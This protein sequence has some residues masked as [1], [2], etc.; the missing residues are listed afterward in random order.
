[1]HKIL[2]NIERNPASSEEEIVF[3]KKEFT[4]ARSSE[5]QLVRQHMQQVTNDQEKLIFSVCTSNPHDGFKALR[6]IDTAKQ[7]NINELRVGNKVF[8]GEN[9]RLHG[10]VNFGQ[11]EYSI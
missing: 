5:R 3:A 2:L 9:V 1:M 11:I 7:V 4:A 6:N 10:S 8:T